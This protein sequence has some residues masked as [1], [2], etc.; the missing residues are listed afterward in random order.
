MR[1]FHNPSSWQNGARFLSPDRQTYVQTNRQRDRWIDLLVGVY[2]A[3]R[4]ERERWVLRPLILRSSSI[5]LEKHPEKKAAQQ[6]AIFPWG[7]I[8][9]ASSRISQSVLSCWSRDLGLRPIPEQKRQL[10]RE[11]KIIC[12]LSLS[13][14]LAHT[15]WH[16]R[17]G[18]MEAEA[19]QAAGA[20]PGRSS[21]QD[22]KKRH[23]FHASSYCRCIEESYQ[24][25]FF[26]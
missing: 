6:L 25:V 4:R 24:L 1:I 7:K 26:S 16:N 20:W 10:E 8:W 2:A 15:P 19:D 21:L 18:W 22:D 13:L 5:A 23:R 17:K 12:L 14:S 3:R 9:P 11:E